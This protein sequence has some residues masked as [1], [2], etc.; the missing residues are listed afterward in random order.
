MKGGRF[1]EICRKHYIKREFTSA[2]TPQL[3][4][5]AERGLTLIEKVAKASAF[6]T[7]VSFVGTQLPAT[8][9][10]WAEAHNNSCD[11]PNRSATTSNKD[12]KSDFEVWHGL[13]PPPILV[14]WL[15][16]Y[17][18]RTMRERKTDA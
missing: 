8:E 17:F 7:Q 5:V 4:G 3:N 14:Q 9:T 1:A 15:Q 16:P 10:L 11:V 12:K 18:Y 2:R 6:Q 13:K